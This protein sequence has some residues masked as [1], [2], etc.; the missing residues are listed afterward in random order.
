MK[1]VLV[2]IAIVLGAMTAQAHGHAAPEWN[3]ALGFKGEATGFKI[4]LGTY[5]FNGKGTLSCISALG[6]TVS[7]PVN[8]TMDARP[9]SLQ[10]AVGHMELVGEALEIALFDC[11]PADILGTYYVAQGQAA[12][13]LGAGAVAA[14]RVDLPEVAFQ[15][16]VELT[17]GLGF[18]LGLNRMKI[19]AAQGLN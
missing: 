9:L 12:I 14:T 7:Y 6:Q 19:E 15:L 16:S 13:G 17:K 1:K 8:V 10:I 11:N 18:N 5:E 2:S 4:L 3:C